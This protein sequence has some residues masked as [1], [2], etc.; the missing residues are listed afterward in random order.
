MSEHLCCYISRINI[1]HNKICLFFLLSS[2][3]LSGFVLYLVLI[4]FCVLYK[5]VMNVKWIIT[6]LYDEANGSEISH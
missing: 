3:M 4:T 5:H 2:E 6:S 1:E